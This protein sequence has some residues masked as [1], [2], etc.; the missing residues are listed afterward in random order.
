VNNKK[1]ALFITQKI[2]THTRF[3][4][5]ST[6]QVLFIPGMIKMRCQAKNIYQYKLESLCTDGSSDFFEFDVR[7]NHL[8]DVNN[9]HQV[10]LFDVLLLLKDV[11]K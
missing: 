4:P 2:I 1:S 10:N 7:D 11:S 9:D 8:P 6:I 5:I 3:D